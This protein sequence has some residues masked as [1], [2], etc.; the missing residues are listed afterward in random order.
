MG[1]SLSLSLSI[2]GGLPLLS[3][4]ISLQRSPSNMLTRR[5][6]ERGRGE[7]A[8]G[9]PKHREVTR[10]P[11][12]MEI[13]D[14]NNFAHRGILH[15]PHSVI[16]FSPVNAHDVACTHARSRACPRTRSYA[17]SGEEGMEGPREGYH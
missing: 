1:R 3:R 15:Y 6:G 8:R 5:Q 4:L 7:G 11:N 9:Y 13:N 12:A 16:E 10:V 17:Y 14:I 2:S